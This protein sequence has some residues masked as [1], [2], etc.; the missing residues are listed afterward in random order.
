MDHWYNHLTFLTWLTSGCTVSGFI[1]SVAALSEILSL[2]TVS[3]DRFLV[4][5]YPLIKRK[6]F[7]KNQVSFTKIQNEIV[8]AKQ[9]YS[10]LAWKVM[11]TFLTQANGM[12]LLVW[13][14]AIMFSI[15][16]LVGWNRYVSEVNLHFKN[17]YHSFYD[18]KKIEQ[19]ICFFN[20]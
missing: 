1:G 9:N 11:L 10:M 19:H 18:S 4:I 17:M 13:A 5:Q 2:A 8:G 3:L 12:I 6:Q 20:Y 7:S 15:F 14:T 16:P